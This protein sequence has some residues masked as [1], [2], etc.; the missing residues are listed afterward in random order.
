MPGAGGRALRS[1]E[2]ELPAEAAS[3]KPHEIYRRILRIPRIRRRSP[4]CRLL[5]SSGAYTVVAIPDYCMTILR[6]VDG[7]LCVAAHVRK[8]PF[9]KVILIRPEIAHTVNHRSV[10]IGLDRSAGIASANRCEHVTNRTIR[11]ALRN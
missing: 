6:S 2:E 7:A 9:L 3:L 5:S 1:D 11:I 10:R 4:A 8:T